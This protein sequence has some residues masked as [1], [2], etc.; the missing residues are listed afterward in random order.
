MAQKDSVK[1]PTHPTTAQPT[2][3]ATGRVV[4]PAVSPPTPS[5]R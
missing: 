1:A 2:H 5:E 4:A 3:P